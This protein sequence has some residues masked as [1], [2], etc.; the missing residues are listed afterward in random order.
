MVDET[1][2]DTTPSG[3]EVAGEQVEAKE[4]EAKKTPY[5]LLVSMYNG[6]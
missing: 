6:Q 5:S 4:P 2:V 1:F 3:P